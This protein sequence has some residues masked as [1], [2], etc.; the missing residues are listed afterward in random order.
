MSN[1]R[2]AGVK[3][4]ERFG[5]GF[6]ERVKPDGLQ[7]ATAKGGYSKKE[8]LAEFRG[9]EKCVSIDEGE[10]NLVDKF[11]GLVDSGEKFNGKAKSYLE[12]HGVTFGGSGGGNGGNNPDAPIEPPSGGK[13]PSNPTEPPSTINPP[14]PFAPPGS[15]NQT[16][17]Q[18][19]DINNTVIGDG[20]TVNIGQENSVDK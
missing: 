9:R 1:H 3:L 19:N 14:S 15:T 16:V 18:D 6:T 20:N 17:N 5:K 11:Q 12:S 13:P 2:M 7:D 10:G 8:L 4:D